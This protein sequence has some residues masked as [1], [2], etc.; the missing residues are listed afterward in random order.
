MLALAMEVIDPAAEDMLMAEALEPPVVDA[1]LV[2]VTAPA[3]KP[4]VEALALRHEAE[5]PC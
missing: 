1:V 3:V 5:A 2:V 4:E